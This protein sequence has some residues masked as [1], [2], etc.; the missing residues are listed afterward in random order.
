M[1]L[2]R[3]FEKN[4]LPKRRLT[5]NGPHSV[6]SQK[7]EIFKPILL[8]NLTFTVLTTETASLVK[9]RGSKGK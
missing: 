9:Q 7:I 4:V 8:R 1:K 6:I 3:R 2:D 5:F